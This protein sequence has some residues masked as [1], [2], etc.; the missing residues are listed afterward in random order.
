M[1]GRRVRSRHEVSASDRQQENALK[2]GVL[3]GT[4][5]NICSH[6]Q[7][8]GAS[9]LRPP[10]VVSLALDQVELVTGLDHHRLAT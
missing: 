1:L 10:V 9:P 8:V 4:D 3:G 5:D 7:L 2:F 6:G